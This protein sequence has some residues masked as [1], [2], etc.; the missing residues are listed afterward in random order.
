[1]A[2]EMKTLKVGGKTYEVVDQAARDL[3]AGMFPVGATYTTGT[4]EAPD[5]PGTWELVSKKFKNQT[6][7]TGIF[8]PSN[9]TVRN[10]TAVF[11][12]DS[13]WIRLGLTTTKAISSSTE[14][15]TVTIENIGLSSPYTTYHVGWT[16]KGVLR[17]ESA[18]SGKLTCYGVVLEG[19]ATSLE[20]G[21]QFYINWE[22]KG[23]KTN[24]LDAFCDR[25]I[26]Q[27]TA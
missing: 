16:G 18:T 21:V 26:W 19:T 7:E 24:K 20:S 10:Q 12:D 11:T 3:I 14:L 2:A 27:R 8:T 25:F 17:L 1:M 6:I 5:L 9:C 23:T 22:Y 13:V 4:N 15:G